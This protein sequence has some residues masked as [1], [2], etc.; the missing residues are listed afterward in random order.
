MEFYHRR[1]IAYSLGNVAGYADFGLGGLLST[2]CILHVTLRSD[3]A[4]AAARIIPTELVDQ[5]RPVPGGDAVSV[6]AQ[7]SR[8]D[9][10][11]RAARIDADGD[12]T[13]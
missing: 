13:P 5:G 10:G 3:S 6:I 12:V 4:F 11:G 9:F 2:S 8:E 1:L 7:L